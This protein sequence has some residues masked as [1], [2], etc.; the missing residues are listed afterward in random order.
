MLAGN[1]A[2]GRDANGAGGAAPQ[3]SPRELAGAGDFIQPLAPIVAHAPRENLRFP[4]PRRGFETSKLRKHFRDAART[5][6]HVLVIYVLPATE[7][8]EELAGADRLDLASQSF[9]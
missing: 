6:E 3:A 4:G 5:F 7:E 8:L 9:D 1:E 2:N